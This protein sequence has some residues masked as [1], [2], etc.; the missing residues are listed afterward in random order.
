MTQDS[1]TVT[2]AGM[3][4]TEADKPIPTPAAIEAYLTTDAAVE[5]VARAFCKRMGLDPDGWVPGAYDRNLKQ[6]E[7]RR[8]D[9][10]EAIAMH[11]ALKEVLG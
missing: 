4:Q 10:R 3:A 1:P 8:Q 11:L 6:W 9:A 5:A 7:F 2:F